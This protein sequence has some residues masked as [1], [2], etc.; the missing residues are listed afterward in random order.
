M[1]P[2]VKPPKLLDQLKRCLH[3]KHYSARTVE[4][5]VYWVRWFI[6]F[7]GLC[8]PVE[9]GATEVKAFLSHLANE[10]H[11]AVSTHRQAL[12]AL[13]FLYKEVLGVELPWLDDLHRPTKPARRPPY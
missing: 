11:V 9:M 13:L 5:Y 3:D 2:S 6:R 4:V 10:R 7:H 8:H 12:C 1:Q